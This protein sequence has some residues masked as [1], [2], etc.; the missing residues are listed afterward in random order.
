MDLDK[1]TSNDLNQQQNY[2]NQ[3]LFL[4]NYANIE[5]CHYHTLR[6]IGWTEND[7]QNLQG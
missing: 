2:V 5:N 7:Y 1:G 4:V 6:D 3:P